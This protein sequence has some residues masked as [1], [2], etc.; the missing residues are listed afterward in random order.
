MQ[1]AVVV[2]SLFATV[3]DDWNFVVDFHRSSILDAAF[4]YEC[5]IGSYV[6]GAFVRD[7]RYLSFVASGGW[8]RDG[9]CFLDSR[10]PAAGGLN[11]TKYSFDAAGKVE[12]LASLAN[13][14]F[15][16]VADS[17][18]F[19]PIMLTNQ[20]ESFVHFWPLPYFLTLPGSTHTTVVK[21]PDETVDGAKCAVF[22]VPGAGARFQRVFLDLEKGCN[23][24]RIDVFNGAD[25]VF[26]V[27]GVE[28]SETTD[29]NGRPR[30][31][32]VK[33]WLDVYANLDLRR[34]EDGR[35]ERQGGRKYLDVPSQRREFRVT[36]NSIML[37]K[38]RSK[39]SFSLDIPKDAIPRDTIRKIDPPKD[40]VPPM[41]NPADLTASLE[42]ANKERDDL[43]RDAGPRRPSSSSTTAYIG[44]AIA[45][46]S[47][48]VGSLWYRR[49]TST[50]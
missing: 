20:L 50:H 12:S 43:I 35:I 33:A 16:P 31:F 40:M 26:R 7:N 28:L 49:R 27:H 21:E 32:P 2:V 36:A 17:K 13:P 18:K 45:G 8:H 29:F 38:G 42:R 48:L 47:L 10:Q 4:D 5:E 14:K 19:T 46:A 22:R 24:R 39:E 37:N 25:L 15:R 9:V 3:S 44:C 6:D 1:A 11:G 23:A 34:T 30:W 41:M